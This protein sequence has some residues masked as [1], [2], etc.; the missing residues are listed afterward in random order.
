MR[1][2]PLV[3]LAGWLGCNPRNL[4]RY[5]K[6]YEQNGFRVL[7]RIAS[8]SMV[9]EACFEEVPVRRV[10]CPPK[11]PTQSLDINRNSSIQDHAWDILREVHLSNCKFFIFHAFSNGGC[12]VWEHVRRIMDIPAQVPSEE[13]ECL[14]V[15]ASLRGRTAGVVFDSCPSIELDKIGYAFRYC[16]LQ[17]RLEVLPT[18][19]ADIAFLPEFMSKSKKE[20][21]R[22]RGE[23]YFCA[24]RDDPMDIPQLYLYSESDALIR[25]QVVDDLIRHRRH[26]MSSDRIYSK[27]WKV[28]RHCAHLLDHPEEYETTI[29]SFIDC[30]QLESPNS[31]L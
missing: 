6:L 22:A 29:S 17:E 24:L 15:V 16:T 20:R 1:E 27:K 30:C 28:S 7:P 3:V 5:Q 2:K 13:K 12:F 11:W 23:A 4:R 31:R 14:E 25:H 18:Y 10:E 9:L 21:M 26:L 19:G 8:P